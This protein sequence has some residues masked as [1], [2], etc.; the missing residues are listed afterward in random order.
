MSK[1]TL[2]FKYQAVLRYRQLCSQQRTADELGISRTHLRRWIAAY[3][4]GG[5]AALEHP[6]ADMNANKRKNPFIADK[7]DADK[8]PAELREELRY[9]RA[10]NAYLK[11]LDEL[12]RNNA[13]GKKPK[14]SKA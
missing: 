8:T 11:K 6:Q 14:S 5:L 9:L 10:E 3:R 13:T 4:S 12:V 2:N 7:P 1:Y